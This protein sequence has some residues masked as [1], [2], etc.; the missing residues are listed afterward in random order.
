MATVLVLVSWSEEGI[1]T[2]PPDMSELTDL[3][4]P[5]LLS[6]VF[7]PL[8]GHSQREAESAIQY[9]GGRPDPQHLNVPLNIEYKYVSHIVSP[10]M[11]GA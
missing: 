11:V 3:L 9:R 7:P 1:V 5:A 8:L 10:L 2:Y 6:Q 4:A